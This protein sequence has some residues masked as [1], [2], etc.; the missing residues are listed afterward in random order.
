MFGGLKLFV[1]ILIVGVE[2]NNDDVW[3]VLRCK[4]NNWDS[5]VDII[6]IE[7]C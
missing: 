7:G 6:C 2:K 4:F 3:R 1:V 5:L